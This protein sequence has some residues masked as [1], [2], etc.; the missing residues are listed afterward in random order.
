MPE[1]KVSSTAPETRAPW[2]PPTLHRVG[3]AG[4]VFQMSGGAKLSTVADDTGD[5]P[6]KPKGME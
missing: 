3:S 2:Q 6:R 5:A 4:E 1:K